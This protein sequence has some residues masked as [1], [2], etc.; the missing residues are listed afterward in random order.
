M[1]EHFS[2][3]DI[4]NII[5]VWHTKLKKGGKL[6]LSVP[7]FSKCVEYYRK[8]DDIRKVIGLVIGGHKDSHDR[9]GAIFDRKSLTNILVENSFKNI[10]NWDW[11]H[12]THTDCDDYSQA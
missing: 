12:T 5:N 3:N 7:D 2:R 6:R 4:S 9:H 1:L 11:R 10:V 8:T